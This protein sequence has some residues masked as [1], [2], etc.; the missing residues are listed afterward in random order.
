MTL[1]GVSGS[2][3]G[4]ISGTP[5]PTAATAPGAIYVLDMWQGQSLRKLI[6]SVSSTDLW[7][8]RIQIRSNPPPN[9][10]PNLPHP[11][12]MLDLPLTMAGQNTY[13]LDFA[14]GL[15]TVQHGE[16]L[17]LVVFNWGSPTTEASLAWSVN[18]LW[19]PMEG[20]R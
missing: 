9:L 10:N 18:H 16:K 17:Y 11:G 8:G 14:P 12:A 6:V 3:E 4:G 2:A 15:I 19:E 20:K 1:L 7:V 5:F 13:S